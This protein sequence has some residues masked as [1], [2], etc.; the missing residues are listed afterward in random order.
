MNLDEVPSDKKSSVYWLKY[1]DHNGREVCTDKKLWIEH[2]SVDKE[3]HNMGK[4]DFNFKLRFEEAPSVELRNWLL[5]DL[6]IE[7]HTTRPKVITKVLE[8]DHDPVKD[9]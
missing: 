9:I 7:L 5:S 4:C 1:I 6:N 3:N 2:F 8:E